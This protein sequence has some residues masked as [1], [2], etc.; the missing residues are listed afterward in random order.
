MRRYLALIG[1]LAA[2]FTTGGVLAH[3]AVAVEQGDT[4][5][6]GLPVE[7]APTTPAN[8]ARVV[9]LGPPIGTVN[10]LGCGLQTFAVQRVNVIIPGEGATGP[11]EAIVFHP[12]EGIEAGTQVSNLSAEGLCTLVATGESYIRFSGIVQ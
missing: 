12:P 4:V 1:L 9:F 5:L 10:G 7:V 8:V 6:F 3:D 2:V 11:V